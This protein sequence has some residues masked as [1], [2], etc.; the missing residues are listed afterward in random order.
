MKKFIGFLTGRLDAAIEVFKATV[1]R[2]QKIG[3][4]GT[5]KAQSRQLS[6]QWLDGDRRKNEPNG[7]LRERARATTL[8]QDWEQIVRQVEGVWQQLVAARLTG[9]RA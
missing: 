1:R 6:L 5:R 4:T 7:H 9:A 8:K 2:R 3:W